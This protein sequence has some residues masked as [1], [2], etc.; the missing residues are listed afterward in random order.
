M[1]AY[2]YCR[3]HANQLAIT[4]MVTTAGVFTGGP[5][6][7]L[8]NLYCCSLFLNMGGHFSRLLSVT[9]AIV[10][11]KCQIVRS[12]APPVCKI[13]HGELVDYCVRNHGRHTNR[14]SV[15]VP[16]GKCEI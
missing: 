16:C 1:L 9:K 10:D 13:L 15:Y 3:N 12:A 8:N 7:L 6:S 11:A 4:N 5:L 2:F 14:C